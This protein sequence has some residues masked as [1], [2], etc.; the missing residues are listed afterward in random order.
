MREPCRDPGVTAERGSPQQLRQGFRPP[1]KLGDP[2]VAMPSDLT[3]PLL[4]RLNAPKIRFRPLNEEFMLDG[5]EN[6]N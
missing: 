6:G 5:V 3:H 1:K 4:S 2:P